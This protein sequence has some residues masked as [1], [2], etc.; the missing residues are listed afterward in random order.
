V[1]PVVK[2]RYTPTVDQM[3]LGYI[4]PLQVMGLQTL[5]EA[6]RSSRPADFIAAVLDAIRDSYHPREVTYLTKF[7]LH[8]A[9]ARGLLDVAK[10]PA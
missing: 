4:A 8:Q 6:S 3:R 10:I 5:E 2:D 7:I 9:E 1:T